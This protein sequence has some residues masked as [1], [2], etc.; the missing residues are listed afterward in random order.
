M[1][2]IYV[3]TLQNNTLHLQDKDLMVN[4]AKKIIPV[5]F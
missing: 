3:H 1:Y 2:K 5:H 4:G